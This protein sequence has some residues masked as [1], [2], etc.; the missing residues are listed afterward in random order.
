L[1][2]VPN[3]EHLGGSLRVWTFGLEVW[4][5]RLMFNLSL[6]PRCFLG[7]TFSFYFLA[8]VQP[9]HDA[10]FSFAA[11]LFRVLGTGLNIHQLYTFVFKRR[12]DSRM[13]VWRRQNGESGT[14]KFLDLIAD[15]F[16]GEV[17]TPVRSDACIVLTVFVDPRELDLRR[18]CIF[19]CYFGAAG[20]SL[21]LPSTSQLTSLRAASE[22]CR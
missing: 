6:Y 7:W 14:D 20:R 12:R 13:D 19:L 18:Y 3:K 8:L 2:R 9:Y 1:T 21:L 16:Q 22:T 15:P 5:L 4:S 17:S 10:F 11:F